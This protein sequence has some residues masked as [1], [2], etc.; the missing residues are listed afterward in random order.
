M[1]KKY[2]HYKE[3]QEGHKKCITYGFKWVVQFF[4]DVGDGCERKG[5]RD[6]VSNAVKGFSQ[7]QG[8]KEG[9]RNFFDMLWDRRC[10][11]EVQI[12]SLHSGLSD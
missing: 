6:L 4:G 11:M 10:L 7:R 5:M 3:R 8:Y 1:I 12:S 2:K 9:L